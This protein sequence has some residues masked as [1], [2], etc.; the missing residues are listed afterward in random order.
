M[1]EVAFELLQTY[2]DEQELVSA[3]ESSPRIAAMASVL[4]QHSERR[5]PFAADSSIKLATRLLLWPTARRGTDN[6][7]LVADCETVIRTLAV[8]K[9]ATAEQGGSSVVTIQYRE[10]KTPPIVSADALDLP[11]GGLMTE[12]AEIPALPRAEYNLL[13]NDF[14]P[15]NTVEPQPFYPVATRNILGMPAETSDT[16][17]SQQSLGNAMPLPRPPAGLDLLRDEPTPPK[18]QQAAPPQQLAERSDLEVMQQ[19]AV[20]TP[21]AVQAALTELTRRGFRPRDLSLAERL[22]NPDPSVRLELANTLPQLSR[23]DS[24]PWL[25]WLSS[26]PDPL[27]RRSAVS[28]IATGDDPALFDHLRQVEQIETDDE[29]LRLIRRVLALR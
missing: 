16:L 22:V 17:P 13:D 29:V 27:V 6:E 26:D 18:R 12:L 28:I 14:G 21:H 9:T 25:I 19:L 1:A 23:I 11:G 4:G 15:L 5:G 8:D 20:G 24:R 2:L 10:F 3:D 7:Q